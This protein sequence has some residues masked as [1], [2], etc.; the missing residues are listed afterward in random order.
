MNPADIP[1]LLIAWRRPCTISRLFNVIR[2]LEPRRIFVFCDGANPSRSGEEQKVEDTRKVINSSIDWPCDVA[3]YF[4]DSNLGCRDG[5][6]A[7]IDWF[8]NEVDEGIILEDDCIPNL[9]FFSYCAHLLRR[10]RDDPRIWCVSG[11]NFLKNNPVQKDSYYFSRYTLTWGWATWRDRWKQFDPYLQ[12]W[13]SF[14]DSGSLLH[15]FDDPYEAAYWSEIFERTYRRDEPI[16]W[17]D[18]QWFF[19]A[20]TRGALTATPFRNLVS[21]IG[22]GEGATHTLNP[23]TPSH[24]ALPLGSI[25]HPDFVIRHRDADNYTYAHHFGGIRRRKLRTLQQRIGRRLSRAS[26]WMGLR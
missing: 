19:A 17:W 3:K 22:F 15:I 9:D 16:T 7:A 20:L 24:P 10:F 5:P 4:S 23:E 6:V 26:A 11:N 12:Q 21:N 14:R 13:P 25:S 8:F 18:Y 2:T 1:I